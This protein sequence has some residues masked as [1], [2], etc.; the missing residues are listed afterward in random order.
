MAADGIIEVPLEKL[1]CKKQVRTEFEDSSIEGLSTSLRELGQL[2]PL[3]IYPEGDGYIIED[4]ERRCR[5]AK[6]AG[7][8]SLKAIVKGV[9]HDE[10]EVLMRQLVVNCQREDLSPI[11]KAR[12]LEQLITL[13]GGNA[14]KVAQKCGIP[15]ATISQLLK[16]LTLD[17]SIQAKV[18][19]GEIP[20]SMA[21]E[22]AQVKDPVRQGELAS[23]IASN[24]LT[25][26]SLKA[27]SQAKES[28]NPAT[29][30]F[31]IPL[32]ETLKLTL[33]G[34]ELSIAGMVQALESMLLKARKAIKEGFELETLERML[35]DQWKPSTARKEGSTHA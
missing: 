14:S 35:Q 1:H 18:N 22:L 32:S 12:G 20:R 3:I 29:K 33:S 7:L 8:V 28:N 4:G 11:E 24:Q 10:G 16:L 2:V 15:K 21:Y 6:A 27:R 13:S 34:P 19:S 30:R 5:A 26:E 17:P 23:E 25:R 9:K 31:A